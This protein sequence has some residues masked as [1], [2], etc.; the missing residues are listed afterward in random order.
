VLHSRRASCQCPNGAAQ[1]SFGIPAGEKRK[2]LINKNTLRILNNGK[3]KKT[4]EKPKK[5]GYRQRMEIYTTT[6][7]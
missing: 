1:P 3:T 7:N 4:A 5:D 6:L 2:N